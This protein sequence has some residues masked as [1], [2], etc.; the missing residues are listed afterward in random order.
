MRPARWQK[1]APGK[2][3]T[4]I[5]RNTVFRGLTVKFVDVN[6]GRVLMS[7]SAEKEYD[8]DSVNKALSAMARSIKKNLEKARGGR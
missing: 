8:A 1:Q 4:R 7:S 2:A 6:S 3:E 5:K